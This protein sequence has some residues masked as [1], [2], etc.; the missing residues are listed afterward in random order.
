MERTF[1]KTLLP[2]YDVFDEDRYFEPAA[3]PQILELGTAVLGI[4]ICEDIWNDRD[5]WRRRRYHTDPVQE[6]VA[7]GAKAIINLSASPFTAGKQKHREAMLSDLAKKYRVPFFY[8]NQVGGNDDLVFDGRSCVFDKEGRL[9]AR[10]RGFEEDL[11]IADPAC[12]D[13]QRSQRT[14]SHP[15]PR[16]GGLW[17]WARATTCTSAAFPG[18]FWAFPGA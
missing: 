17:F 12:R 10:A 18:F 15:S 9:V 4:S 14:I 3:E 13:R 8:V 11:I 7:A 6:L 2:T 16:S 1:K 5:F